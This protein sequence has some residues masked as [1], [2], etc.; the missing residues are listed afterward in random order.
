MPTVSSPAV[1][2]AVR[3]V[4]LHLA[5]VLRVALRVLRCVA[6]VDARVPRVALHV[7]RA[8]RAVQNN[9]DRK[10]G[11]DALVRARAVCTYA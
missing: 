10:T 3:R 1:T 4:V 11:D 9:T 8:V 6:C 2:A 7:L 5:A